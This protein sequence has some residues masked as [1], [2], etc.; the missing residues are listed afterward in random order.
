MINTDIE[1]ILKWSQNFVLTEEVFRE[2]KEA[3]K[4]PVQAAV[5]VINTP[6]DLKL[7]ITDC[8]LYVQVVTLQKQYENEL[9]KDLKTGIDIDFEW[10][11]YRTQIINQP[12]LII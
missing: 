10:E 8:K 6:S 4:N 9:L 5:T 7:N 2:G 12:A 11:R 3:T 1:L